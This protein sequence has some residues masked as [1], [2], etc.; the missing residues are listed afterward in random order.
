[1]ATKPMRQPTIYEAVKTKLGREP[2]HVELTAEVR[3]ILQEAAD[4]RLVA[5]AEAGRLPHQRKGKRR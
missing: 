2:N 5:Q 3:R 4:E 1:M